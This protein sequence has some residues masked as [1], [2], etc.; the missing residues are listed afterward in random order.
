MRS[1]SSI[2]WHVLVHMT[3]Y[4]CYTRE[5]ELVFHRGSANGKQLLRIVAGAR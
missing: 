2:D 5:L 3:Y 1:P 4:L